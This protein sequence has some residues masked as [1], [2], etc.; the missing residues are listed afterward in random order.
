MMMFMTDS[1]G[2][3]MMRYHECSLTFLL[4][5]HPHLPGL[6]QSRNLKKFPSPQQL[7]PLTAHSI[8]LKL[9]CH[10]VEASNIQWAISPSRHIRPQSADRR[11]VQDR[12][13][14]VCNTKTLQLP[15]LLVRREP[16]QAR[17]LVLALMLAVGEC[18]LESPHRLS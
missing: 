9:P 6:L 1:W 8:N 4:K 10:P 15:R 2:K 13:L 14:D 7:Q 11:V 16:T 3:M 18:Q 12:A 17:A 5:T